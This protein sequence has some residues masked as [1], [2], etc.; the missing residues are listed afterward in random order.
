MI[1]DQMLTKVVSDFAKPVQCFIRSGRCLVLEAMEAEKAKRSAADAD[2]ISQR[3]G[4]DRGVP[5]PLLESEPHLTDRPN[6]LRGPSLPGHEHRLDFGRERVRRSDPGQ[7]QSSANGV[8]SSVSFPARV[9]HGQ[10]PHG[11]LSVQELPFDC[12]SPRLVSEPF[13]LRPE[14]WKT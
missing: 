5:L 9:R 7:E 1:M 13:V 11:R 2:A 10:T 4:A 3:N 12:S 6:T 14:N 8:R